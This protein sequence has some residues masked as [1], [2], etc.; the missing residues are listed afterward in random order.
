MNFKSTC[1]R[2]VFGTLTTNRC[3]GVSTQINTL[4]NSCAYVFPDAVTYCIALKICGIEYYNEGS[5]TLKISNIESKTF[6]KP[7]SFVNLYFL[8]F[9]SSFAYYMLFQTQNTN[10]NAMTMLPTVYVIALTSKG[11]CPPN[12]C[13]PASHRNIK[14]FVLC[15]CV[16]PSPTSHGPA[17][18]HRPGYFRN[19]NGYS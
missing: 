8:I 4:L 9:I 2:F 14:S 5:N 19:N 6:R 3:V 12:G 11:K 15:V 13:Y 16:L 10:T 1:I 18:Q 17:S 7:E